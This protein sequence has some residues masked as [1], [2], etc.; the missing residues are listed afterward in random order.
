M[1][2]QEQY[3]KCQQIKFQLSTRI[4]N[5][6]LIQPCDINAEKASMQS[7]FESFALQISLLKEIYDIDEDANKDE[8]IK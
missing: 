7:N 3:R 8:R 5:L 4:E 1:N 6:Q 2:F